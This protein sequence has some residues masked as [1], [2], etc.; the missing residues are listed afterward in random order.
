VVSKGILS[1]LNAGLIKPVIP[2]LG[3][4]DWFGV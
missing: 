3:L 1:R 4:A 2:I